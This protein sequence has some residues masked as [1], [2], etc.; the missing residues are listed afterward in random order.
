MIKWLAALMAGIAVL[1]FSAACGGGDGDTIDLGDGNSVS[2]G[3]DLPDDFPDD[4]PI[5][6][7]ADFQGSVQA[8]QDGISGSASTWTTGDDY[9]DVVAFYESAFDGSDAWTSSTSGNASGSAYWSVEQDDGLV[10]YVAVT[11][12]EET[13]ITAIISDDPNQASS[14]GSSSD[15]DSSSDD[16]DSSSDDASDDASDDGS[17]DDG[18]S[19]DGSDDSASD[20]SSGS[21]DVD[22]PEEVD[23][24]DDYPTDLIQLPDGARVTLAQSYSS[25]GQTTYMVGFI[26]EKDA[27]EA[28]DEI[29][30]H[31]TGQGYT[32]SVKTT[33]GSGFYAAYAENADGTGT[34]IAVSANE[35]T[36]E[37][38]A[39]GIVQVTTGL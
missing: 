38:Y 31:L 19:D 18:S 39:E 30:A 22:L 5:Y 1:S 6:D 23:I 21:S 28:G 11:G 32:Q 33:D 24:P 27:N 34:I 35:G 3:G 29:D 4:F 15:D 13:T 36:Y 9:D 10:A 37:G 16:G 26:T 12:G 20:P 8:E 25:N 14:D 17:S 7:G 2:V